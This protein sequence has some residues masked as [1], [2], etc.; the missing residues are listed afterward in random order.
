MATE[1]Q[2]EKLQKVLADRGLGSRRELEKWISG[3]RVTV[4]GEVAHLGQRVSVTDRIEVDG[5]R[6]RSGKSRDQEIVVINKSAGVVCT[7]QDPEGRPT[8]F[9]ELP[10]LKGSRWVAVGRLDLQTTGLML[11]TTDGELAN[12]LMHPSTG[13]DREYAVR[14]NQRLDE[15]TLAHLCNGVEIDGEWLKFSDIQFYDGTD[16][17]SWYHVVLMEGKNR[18]VRRL[19]E[20]VGCVVSRLK[21]VR[22]GPVILP[23]WL[24]VGQWAS[25]NNEDMKTM[26]KLL[27][28]RYR[29]KSSGQQRRNRV[30]KTTCLLPYPKLG[31]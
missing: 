2:T 19:F 11:V 15:E 27:G 5:K 17:N 21:R 6:L 7:R 13:L 20:S 25:M 23:S 8:I 14:I 22:Y 9:D 18:E 1:P 4:N 30:A 31:S 26:Y 3:G 10:T 12:R 16:N 28:L 29:V 24:R